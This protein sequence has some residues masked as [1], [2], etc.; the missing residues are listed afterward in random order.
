MARS[1]LAPAEIEPWIPLMRAWGVSTVARSSR[2]F[3]PAYRRAG[4][5][6]SEAWQD[7]RDAFVARHMAQ[8]ESRGE[9]L[10]R[11]GLPTRRHLALI[12]WAYSPDR[13][14]LNRVAR[15]LARG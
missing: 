7:R 15:Q 9:P 14:R 12:A 2:G 5:D 4:G 8:V 13:A 11:D 6:L 3:W 10:W 1:W